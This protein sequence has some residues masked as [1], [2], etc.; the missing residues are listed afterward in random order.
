MQ[1]PM[2]YCDGGAWYWII[3]MVDVSSVDLDFVEE[4]HGL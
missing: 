3:W 4:R 1:R 2:G